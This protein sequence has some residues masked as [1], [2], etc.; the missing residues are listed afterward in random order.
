MHCDSR[1]LYICYQRVQSVKT[2]RGLVYQARP[3][4]LAHW[5][6]CGPTPTSRKREKWV[7]LDRLRGSCC[8]HLGY[9]NCNVFVCVYVHKCMG[10]IM[11]GGSEIWSYTMKPMAGTQSHPL[12]V[13]T[14]VRVI[15]SQ[16]SVCLQSEG[17]VRSGSSYTMAGTQSHLLQ[18]G[19]HILVMGSCFK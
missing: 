16:S 2:Q 11:G 12:P 4:S 5:K 7:Q 10:I 14:T 18:A 1:V 3:I 6:M 8:S 9:H 19:A 17:L 13:T 15:D